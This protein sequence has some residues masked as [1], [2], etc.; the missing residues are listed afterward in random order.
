MV[1]LGWACR[2]NCST[3]MLSIS[4]LVELLCFWGLRCKQHFP[5]DAHGADWSAAGWW[6]CGQED[7]LGWVPASFLRGQLILNMFFSGGLRWQSYVWGRLDWRPHPQIQCWV[8]SSQLHW[9]AFNP[10]RKRNGPIVCKRTDGPGEFSRFDCVGRRAT[11]AA[12]KA[13]AAFEIHR[14]QGGE[15]QKKQSGIQTCETRGFEIG[16]WTSSALPGQGHEDDRRQECPLQQQWP[17]GI[18]RTGCAAGKGARVLL[19]LLRRKLEYGAKVQEWLSSDTRFCIFRC[20]LLERLE[21]SI[22]SF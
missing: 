8:P 2:G 20:S 5:G 9:H 14:P 17:S 3:E 15:F 10:P 12:T 18:H 6:G 4:D 13:P 19:I 16:R 21:G 11:D 1:F 7:W 22:I